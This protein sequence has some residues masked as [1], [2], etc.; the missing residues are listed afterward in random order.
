M[1]LTSLH[2]TLLFLFSSLCLQA[3]DLEQQRLEWQLKTGDVRNIA[4]F[5]RQY[6]QKKL[7]A[8]NKGSMETL[9]TDKKLAQACY[10]AHFFPPSAKKKC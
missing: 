10:M 7:G 2:F 1:F 5:S 8:V 4:G 6:V 9:L 3:V